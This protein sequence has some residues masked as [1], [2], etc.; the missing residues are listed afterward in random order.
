[1]KLVDSHCHLDS[2]D[3]DADREA[4]I[5]R[6][7]DA[8]VER[9]VAI[10]TGDGPPDLAAGIRLADQHEALYATVGIHP[11]DASKANDESLRMLESLLQHPKVIAIGEIGLDY[12]YDFAPRDTQRSLFTNPASSG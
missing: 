2:S 3:V 7:L 4:V 12:Y 8:G 6:A 11:H 10:G 1:M 5:Q 9:M